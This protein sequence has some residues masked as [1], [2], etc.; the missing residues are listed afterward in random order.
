ML[1]SELI[2]LLIDRFNTPVRKLAALHLSAE[3]LLDAG[4]PTRC[5][6]APEIIHF[7]AHGSI[8]VDLQHMECI[9]E[10]VD[11]KLLPVVLI[12]MF[13]QRHV[14]GLYLAKK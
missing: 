6:P 14:M 2:Q 10:A 13:S 7:A 11:K 8:T 5:Q 9:F 12:Q 4:H 3:S 1:L